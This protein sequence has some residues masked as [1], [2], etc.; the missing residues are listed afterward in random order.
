MN[1]MAI[2]VAALGQ[3]F[4]GPQVERHA[5]P[6]PV[7][8]V[9]RMGDVGLGLRVRVRRPSPRGSRGRR[10]PS[11]EPGGV[12][13]RTRV[14]HLVD[15]EHATGR[16]R[17]FTFSSRTAS[18]ERVTGAPSPRGTGAASGGSG[19]C[20]G[21]RRRSRSKPPAPPPP[22]LG[23]GDLTSRR[24]AVPDRLEDGVGEPQG[25]DVL[26]GLLAQ[27]VVDPIDLALVGT[28]VVA[29]ASS[30]RAAARSWPK[31]FSMTTR[32]NASGACGRRVGCRPWCRRARRRSV[33]NRR[34]A[35]RPGSERGSLLV[36]AEAGRPRPAR[37]G[38][39]A[40]RSRR[41]RNS[42]GH[43]AEPR[44]DVVPRDVDIRT[45]LLRPVGVARG[46]LERVVSELLVGPGRAGDADHSEPS[47]QLPAARRASAG[48]SFR[49]VRSP[50]AP[51]TTSTHG[52][53]GRSSVSSTSAS[54]PGSRSAMAVAG[55]VI[56][57]RALPV[58]RPAG[59]EPDGRG[60]AATSS[61][62][63]PALRT[64]A[65]R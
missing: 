31:G 32:A 5:G 20:R 24:A 43:V 29:A 64:A 40:R 38:Q 12:L 41:C 2:S 58:A 6:A 51:N 30:S 25:Q 59:D 19:P 47:G 23:D 34:T 3:P 46:R 45:G 22:I 57:T 54:A 11:I 21:A 53:T 65:G 18:A 60:C 17:T 8:G 55:L 63:A 44:D 1:W 16:W 13:A 52:G 62:R 49:P 28:G 15:V 33:G 14:G 50:E 56:R 39:T 37:G 36:P 35:V 42:A 9:S 61:R 26:D 4:A 7:V 10:L 27:V 48:S